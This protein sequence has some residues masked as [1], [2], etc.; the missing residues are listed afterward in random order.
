MIK[1]RGKTGRP[2]RACLSGMDSLLGFAA[3]GWRAPG[4]RLG[5]RATELGIKAEARPSVDLQ[6][7]TG[8][9]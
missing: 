8:G 5:G 2:D 1:V 7:G 4:R 6:S 9:Y 3:F